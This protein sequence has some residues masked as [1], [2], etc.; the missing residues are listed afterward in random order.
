MILKRVIGITLGISSFERGLWFDSDR[1]EYHPDGWGIKFSLVCGRLIRPVPRFWI[2]G[3]NPWKGDEPWF[4]I[5]IPLIVLPFISIA[6]GKYGIY[7]GAKTFSVSSEHITDDRYGKWLKPSEK[8][9]DEDP[10]EYLTISASI[11]STRWI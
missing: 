7:L 2:K 9:T 8:G 3:S 10:R 6:L 4:V 5:R 11:R 1:R